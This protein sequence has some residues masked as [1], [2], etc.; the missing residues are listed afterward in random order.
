MARSDVARGEPGSHAANRSPPPEPGEGGRPRIG[1][2]ACLLGQAVRYDGGHKR[3]RFLTDVLG[4]YVEWVPICPE[5]EIG[6][7][8]PRPPIRLER[9]DGGKI[10]L[11]MPSTGEDLTER[12]RGYV[13]GRVA[14]LASLGLCGYV[15]KSDSPSCG[16]ARV[17]VFDANDGPHGGGRGPSRRR[18]KGRSRRD[19][20]GLFAAGLMD[21]LPYLP[22]E[23]EDRLN[24]PRLRE[25][26]ISRVF[27]A[28]RWRAMEAKGLSRASLMRFH[29]RHELH[30]MARSQA[31]LRRLGRLLA[32]PSKPT[33]LPALA[34]TYLARFM[35]VMS[36]V[37]TRKGHATVLEHVAGHLSD[38]LDAGDRAELA[39]AIRGYRR[40]LTPLIV[41]LTLLRHHARQLDITYLKDRVYLEPPRKPGME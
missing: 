24:D 33:D 18:G 4:P 17:E 39:E 13:D 36:R 14:L 26:F 38:R 16:M 19:G 35:A 25:N 20:R 29:R 2:S 34:E 27:A 32:Q 12:M 10:H 8:T 40:G 22:V 31:G 3:D 7:G 1:I 15:L 9:G 37:P 41:P 21:A 23:D 28:H 11:V 6:L 30:C 5:V